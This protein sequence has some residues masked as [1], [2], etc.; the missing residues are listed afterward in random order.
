[1]L[2]V[3]IEKNLVENYSCSKC[4][5]YEVK[6]KYLNKV[7]QGFTLSN[8]KINKYNWKSKEFFK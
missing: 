1:M 2:N 7:L 6:I 8:K 4:K 5:V 3:M